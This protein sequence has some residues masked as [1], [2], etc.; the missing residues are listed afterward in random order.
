MKNRYKLHDRQV[1]ADQQFGGRTGERWAVLDTTNN[2]IVDEGTTRYEAQQA[3]KNWNAG[4]HDDE[5]VETLNAEGPL[6]GLV[7]RAP[8]EPTTI[9]DVTDEPGK[10]WKVTGPNSMHTAAIAR[11]AEEAAEVPTAEAMRTATYTDPTTGWSQ[12]VE[13]LGN[14]APS[15]GG[16][17]WSRVRNTHNEQADVPD[18]TLRDFHDEPPRLAPEEAATLRSRTDLLPLLRDPE[19]IYHDPEGR[20]EWFARCP[21]PADG[22]VD[23]PVLGNVPT[24]QRCADRFELSL[25][26]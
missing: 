15:G 6:R 8:E 14:A 22:V 4:L 5:L 20:C 24:C 3:V 19:E 10:I 25:V 21:N 11:A 23:H 9:D 17:H 1:H 12:V 16:V 13:V 18:T 2:R 26:K 7:E